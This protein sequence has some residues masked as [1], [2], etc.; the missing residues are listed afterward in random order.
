MAFLEL[1][2]NAGAARGEG[3]GSGHKVERLVGLVRGLGKNADELDGEGEHDPEAAED[4]GELGR[5]LFLGLQVEEHDDED[6]QH[7]DRAG[8]NEDL[9]DPDEEGVEADEQAGEADEGGDHGKG[10]C[11]GISQGDHRDAADQHDDRKEP[12]KG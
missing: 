1:A 8:V 12:E 6:E 4:R 3:G 5:P 7:H 2:G 9:D 10:G 11:D